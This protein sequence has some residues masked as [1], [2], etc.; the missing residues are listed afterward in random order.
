MRVTGACEWHYQRTMHATLRSFHSAASECSLPS[1]IAMHSGTHTRAREHAHV[2]A[3]A[4]EDTA[5]ALHVYAPSA[6]A[7][8]GPD[9]HAYAI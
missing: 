5:L 4:H 2:N 1:D 8:S 6:G 3:R 9:M 7:L